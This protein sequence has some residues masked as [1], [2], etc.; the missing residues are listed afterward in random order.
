MPEENYDEE[1][2][3]NI[4]AEQGNLDLKYRPLFAD[5]PNRSKTGTE[6]KK[7]DSENTERK[8]NQSQTNELSEN[9]KHV[10]GI[11]QNKITTPEQSEISTPKFSKPSVKPEKDKMDR[12][13]FYHWGATREIE[14]IIRR[15]NNIPE[16]RRLVEQRNNLSRPGTL[17]CRYNH[18]SQRTIFAPSRP[19]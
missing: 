17:R 19:N 7:N 3:I 16:T 2:V 11:E 15:R 4:L 12:E 18:Q 6:R 1:Y 10:N 14:D 5:Q 8:I 9:E 13:I